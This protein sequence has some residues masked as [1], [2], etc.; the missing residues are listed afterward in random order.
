[1]SLTEPS[2]AIAKNRHC[3][4]HHKGGFNLFVAQERY[5]KFYKAGVAARLAIVLLSTTTDDAV[6]LAV[7]WDT[8]A[9]E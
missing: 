3:A 9:T 1:M 2:S 7:A 5:L 8:S 4:S 6:A